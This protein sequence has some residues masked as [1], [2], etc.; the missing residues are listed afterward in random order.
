M[1]RKATLFG[2]ILCV[3]SLTWADRSFARARA[4]PPSVLQRRMQEQQR[5]AQ[6]PPAP[7]NGKKQTTQEEARQIFEEYSDEAWQEA[8]GAT[9]DEWQKI[10][11][12]LEAVKKSP[13][14]PTIPL[15][16]YGSGEVNYSYSTSQSNTSGGGGMGNVSGGVRGGAG[17]SGGTGGGR[18]VFSSGGGTGGSSSAAGGVTGGAGG[19]GLPPGAQGMGSGFG[20]GSGY[21]S[22]GSA[23]G[24]GGFGYSFGG[25]PGPVK[26]KVEDV[27]LGW[28]WR[29]PSLNK[30]PAQLSENEKA[31]EQ[32]LE[33]LEAQ[34][35]DA[36]QVRQRIEA[37]R[38]VRE[39]I[40]AQ[41]KEAMRQL[42]EVVTPQQEA[43]LI[44]MGYLD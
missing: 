8:L 13:R 10:K 16:V 22:G 17:G 7:N 24:G 26:K 34:H 12:R 3:L 5:R 9:P 31:C 44:L 20:G 15:S 27:S 25:P 36:T 28:Q 14:Q 18:Y 21:A 1:R 4:V 35:P 43:K 33:A 42:R 30:A 40:A 37:V 32:L 41:R 23:S 6:Q 29:R 2:M 19:A 39:Q 38:Q 11:P